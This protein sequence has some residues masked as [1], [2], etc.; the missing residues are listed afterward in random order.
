MSNPVVAPPAKIRPRALWYWIGALLII[1]GIV[2][3]IAMIV[4]GVVSTSRTVD[5][6]AR[7]VAP[8]EGQTL[9]FSQSGTFTIYYE[10]DS[11]VDGTLYRSPQEVP[12]GLRISF[13]DKDGQALPVSSGGS[14]VTFSVSGRSGQSVGKVTIPQAGVYVAIVQTD[15]A[16]D[17][18]VIALGKGVLGKLLSYLGGGLAVGFIGF[19]SG[20]VI[21]IVTGVKRGRRKR[22]RQGAQLQAAQQ[23][24]YASKPYASPYPTVP[25]TDMPTGTGWP[26]A[27]TQPAPPPAPGGGGWAPPPPPP[28]PA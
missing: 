26:Q 15:Q 2:G 18:F 13:I 24:T 17:Q 16:S 11:E 10:W 12:S 7:F 6:F 9:N 23:G 25:G 28:P 19:V 27:P 3:G 20:L 8:T 14:S 5:K 22:E 21:L 1:G 4:A